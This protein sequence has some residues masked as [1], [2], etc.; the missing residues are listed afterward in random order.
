MYSDSFSQDERLRAAIEWR[1]TT[2]AR[3][4]HLEDAVLDA[5]F[6]NLVDLLLTRRDLGGSHGAVW[7]L[8]NRQLGWRISS[9][10]RGRLLPDGR[11]RPGPAGAIS[12]DRLVEGVDG[13]KFRWE[14]PAAD[15]VEVTAIRRMTFKAVM[16]D[17]TRKGR[18]TAAIVLGYAIGFGPDELE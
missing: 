15:D 7:A 3:R 13:T 17:A 12:L 10:I 16:S 18:T 6:D 1:E 14:P 2:R 4:P 8:G 5:A 11:T 9:T